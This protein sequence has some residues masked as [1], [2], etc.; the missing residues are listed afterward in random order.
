MQALNSEEAFTLQNADYDATGS[1]EKCVRRIPKNLGPQP[2]FSHNPRSALICSQLG[3]SLG[4]LRC[5]N[6]LRRNTPRH[7]KRRTREEKVG[8]RSPVSR[9]SNWLKDSWPARIAGAKRISSQV[10][11]GPAHHGCSHSTYGLLCC[12]ALVRSKINCLPAAV[13]WTSFP[14]TI[15][16]A[17]S[18]LS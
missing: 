14:I 4:A 1:A 18:A 6:R 2:T 10:Y 16:F 9:L 17:V 11:Q 13:G 12:E 3:K 15:S 8:L 5:R 7:G